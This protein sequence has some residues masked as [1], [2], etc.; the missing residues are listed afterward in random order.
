MTE[1]CLSRLRSWPL[2]VVLVA[3]F[4]SSQAGKM[5]PYEIGRRASLIQFFTRNA[6]RAHS[7]RSVVAWPFLVQ[8]PRAICAAL[9]MQ[10]SLGGRPQRSDRSQS[11]Q[12][13][14]DGRR[15]ATTVL[16]SLAKTSWIAVRMAVL[17]DKQDLSATR[18]PGVL[19]KIKSKRDP[20]HDIATQSFA[21]G[22]HPL[23][24]INA[25]RRQVTDIS[26]QISLFRSMAKRRNRCPICIPAP[27]R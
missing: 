6:S 17:L 11:P 24:W 8:S 25:A 13:N 22:R 15:S 23:I 2:L 26:I 1:P 4:R 19:I 10:R 7:W 3:E 5:P 18:R 21:G 16:A 20:A 12:V 27:G 9:T 14:S